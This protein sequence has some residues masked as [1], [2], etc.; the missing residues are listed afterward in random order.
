MFFTEAL[1]SKP[2]TGAENYFP[3]ANIVFA[4]MLDMQNRDVNELYVVLNVLQPVMFRSFTKVKTPR[5]V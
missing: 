5:R 1:N 4:Q 3:Y 2:T